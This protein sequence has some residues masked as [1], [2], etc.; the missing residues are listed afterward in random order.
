MTGSVQSDNGN[1][2]ESF[3]GVQQASPAGIGGNGRTGELDETAVLIRGGTGQGSI[4]APETM[5][6]LV[7]NQLRIW[8]HCGAGAVDHAADMV[9]MQMRAQHRVD[10]S[11]R[12]AHR[13]QIIGE[14]AGEGADRAAEP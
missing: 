9:G 12:N 4:I 11:R 14:M 7:H 2:G 5:I 1:A 8:K 3:A 13:E 6:R 10:I